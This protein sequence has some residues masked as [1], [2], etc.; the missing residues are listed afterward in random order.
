MLKGETIRK[1]LVQSSEFR[2]FSTSAHLPAGTEATAF[3]SD[4]D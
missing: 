2:K 1:H 3:L 4:Q